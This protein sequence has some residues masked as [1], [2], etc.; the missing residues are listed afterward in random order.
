METLRDDEL[1]WCWVENGSQWAFA[2]IGRRYAGLVFSACLREL[3]DPTLAEDASQAVFL[4]LAQKAPKLRKEGALAGWLFQTAR[5][6]SQSV[7]RQ[8]RRRKVRESRAAQVITIERESKAAS[9][10][11]WNEIAPHL[12]TA[13]ARLKPAER[14]AVLLRCLQGRSLAETGVALGVTEN[15]ARMRVARALDKLRSH[16]AKAGIGVT[17]TLLISLLSEQATQAAP[18]TLLDAIDGIAA[19]SAATGGAAL[20]ASN[21]IASKTAS[22][23]SHNSR[24]HLL[25]KGVTAAM[26]LSTA[27]MITAGVIGVALLGL[28]GIAI[29][30]KTRPRSASGP[31]PFADNVEVIVIPVNQLKSVQKV[32]NRIH[33]DGYSVGQYRKSNLR[34]ISVPPRRADRIR[35]ALAQS[36]IVS[37]NVPT[38]ERIEMEQMSEMRRK[39]TR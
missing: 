39:M 14:E 1:L 37:A 21:L 19:G 5:L 8:E 18:V 11:L 17:V 36:G 31:L 38:Q 22:A 6:V 4:L 9:D 10:A 25:A 16:L 26:A 35:Q 28:G 29:H 15:A 33:V 23:I 2:E 34:H 7:G 32:L 24:A 12:N 3:G 30:N 27:K 20:A 13:L